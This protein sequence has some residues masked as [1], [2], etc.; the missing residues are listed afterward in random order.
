MVV[1]LFF[2]SVVVVYLK[3]QFHNIYWKIICWGNFA[4]CLFLICMYLVCSKWTNLD[5]KVPFK[6]FQ[7][8][9]LNFNKQFKIPE[10]INQI[11]N[12]ENFQLQ[13]AL[14]FEQ[15]IPPEYYDH[16]RTRKPSSSFALSAMVCDPFVSLG[17]LLLCKVSDVFEQT[18]YFLKKKSPKFFSLKLLV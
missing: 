14:F 8:P 1:C 3:I 7:W 18:S 4:E 16:E 15:I 5:E 11:K 17:H 2:T 13:I 9:F 10:F 6:I 12:F